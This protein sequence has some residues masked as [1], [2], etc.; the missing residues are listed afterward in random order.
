MNILY[1]GV[2]A[3][4]T[5]HRADALVRLGHTVTHIDP[6]QFVPK[7]RLASKLHYETGGLLCEK[8]V[9]AAVLSQVGDAQFDLVH[10]DSGRYVGPAL[11]QELGRRFGPVINYNNDDPFGPRDR[12]SWALYRR[13]VPW[14][15][16]LVV[17]RDPNIAEAEALGAKKT[18]RVSF[19]ADEVAHKPRVLTP[20][21]HARW[22]SEVVFVGTW[23]PERGPFMTELIER[24]VPL[25]IYGGR[26]QRAPEWPRLQSAWKG[27]AT[28][29]DDEY[30]RAIQCAKICLGLLS[31]GNRDL[32]TGRTFEVPSLGSVLCAERT[33][34]HQQLYCEGEEAVF[35]ANAAECADACFR[36][37]ADDRLRREIARKGQ[38]RLHQNRTLSEPIM[39]H[40]LEQTAAGKSQ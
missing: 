30:A 9:T 31:K 33:T 19:E 35:W 10:I 16:L 17:L 23:M 13:A 39:A 40:I 24:G 27:P 2:Y 18:L 6:N 22:D 20:E 32:Q 5:Q 34:E 28:T 15:D 11:V 1:L 36:L 21:D 29:T 26:W 7:G 38:E 3:G 37:L 4:T 14:Y 12:G 8:A 25:T